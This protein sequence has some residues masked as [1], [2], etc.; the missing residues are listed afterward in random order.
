MAKKTYVNEVDGFYIMNNRQT[1]TLEELSKKLKIT[2]DLIRQYI[3]ERI[4][5]KTTIP[6]KPDRVGHMFAKTG[7]AV[8]MTKGASELGDAAKMKSTPNQAGHIHKIRETNG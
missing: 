3:D 4:D 6:I 7:G 2:S 5:T 1:M 8:I